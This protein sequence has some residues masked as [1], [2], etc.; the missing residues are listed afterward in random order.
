MKKW[1]IARKTE[2]GDGGISY[3][4]YFIAIVV[5][6]V[7]F[8]FYKFNVSL[9]VVEEVVENG[10]HIAEN[11]TMTSNYNS[12]GAD[13]DGYRT[14]DFEK[15]MQRMHIINPEADEVSQVLGA[16]DA[17]AEA[18]SDQLKLGPGGHPEGGILERL[19]DENSTV[20]IVGPVMIYEPVYRRE[21]ANNGTVLDPDFE[22]TYGVEAWNVYTINYNSNN[23]YSDYTKTT[24]PEAPL[25]K[26][27]DECAG[28]TIEATVGL[29]LAGI[30]NAFAHI[31]SGAG[32][33]IFSAT[34]EYTKFAVT[35]TQSTDIVIAN[36][37]PRQRRH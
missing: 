22:I 23:E 20:S 27:G 34:P 29:T 14:D 9:Y 21:V 8:F 3:A 37:D 32:G 35:A 25:L 16:A 28:A 24:Q 12:I 31:S 33:G 6:S 26:N 1:N 11:R 15:E 30:K 10:L 4:M 2:A 18:L 19:C 17:F 7:L 13:A 5:V 36:R